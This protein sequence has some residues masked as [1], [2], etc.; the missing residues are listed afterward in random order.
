MK[1]TLD[2]SYEICKLIKKSPRRGSLFDKLKQELAPGSSGIRVLFPTH[3]TVRADCL[4]SIIDKVLQ[5]T[6][7]M[8]ID[9][10]RDPEMKSRINGVASQMKSFD[11]LFGVM[12]AQLILV[13]S[14][15]LSRTLQRKDISAAEG[16][17]VADLTVRTLSKIRP[18]EYF[19][20]FWDKVLLT[21]NR[22]QLTEPTLPRRRKV[23]RRLEILNQSILLQ[24]VIII[25]VYIL[26][27][28]T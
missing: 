8:A 9:I 6:W 19:K 28:W 17:L 20:L 22:L 24:P 23:P 15:N 14:D 13:H 10:V 5:E 25:S 11:F 4:K 12:L 27:P 16:Q 21:C 26:K 2:Y 18:E 7:E 3:W 1:D